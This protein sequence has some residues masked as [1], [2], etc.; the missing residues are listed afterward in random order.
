[1]SEHK[2]NRCGVGLDKIR[3]VEPDWLGQHD[4]R[5]PA[6]CEPCWKIANEQERENA[7]VREAIRE[8]RA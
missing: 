8:A 6:L 2:C 1:M 7:R 5:R 3:F 4:G